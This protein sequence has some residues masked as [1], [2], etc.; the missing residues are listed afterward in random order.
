MKDRELQEQIEGYLN[1]TLPSDQM[2]AWG[3]RLAEDA[4]LRR[5]VELHRQLHQDYDSGRLQLRANLR[6]VMEEPLPPEL[7]GASSNKLRR[8]LWPG[9]ILGVILAVLGVLYWLRPSLAGPE[10]PPAKR[11]I[12]PPVLKQEDIP[13]ARQVAPPEPASPIAMSDRARFVP[14]PGMEAFVRGGVRSESIK[15]RVKSPANGMQFKPD[16]K[17]A[18]YLYFKGDIDWPDDQQPSGFILSFFDNRNANKPLVQ[19]PLRPGKDMVGSMSF[20]QQQELELAT[21]LYY[22]TIEEQDKGEV[23]YAG[24]FLVE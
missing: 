8:L 15:I 22:F 11:Q 2:Q 6:A 16:K 21:G 23:L 1:N 24:K 4:E 13:P 9:L 17:G 18:V 7:P 14:N 20:K 3:K 19:T 10:S 12:T 5:Q